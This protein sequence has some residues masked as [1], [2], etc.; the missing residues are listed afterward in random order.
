MIKLCAGIISQAVQCMEKRSIPFAMLRN[1][2]NSSTFR[3]DHVQ[4]RYEV[5]FISSTVVCILYGFW[6]EGG[7]GLQKLKSPAGL[8]CGMF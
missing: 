8:Q 6:H 2:G 3:H 7:Y 4:R 1:L 5:L